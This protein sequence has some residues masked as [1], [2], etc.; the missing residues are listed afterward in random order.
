MAR[1]VVVGSVAVDE[2]ALVEGRVREGAHLEAVS[3]GSRLGGGAANTGTALVHAG[4]HVSLVS[5]VGEDATAD[6]ILA[7][8]REA[9]CDIAPIVRLPGPSTRSF[10]MIDEAGERTVVNLGRAAECGPPHRL[11]PVPADVVYV[12]SR[13]PDLAEVMREKARTCLVVAHAPP[14]VD[15]ARPCHVIVTS[16]SDID[17]G[18]AAAPFAAGRRIGGDTVRWVVVT[19]G[20]RGATAHSA[21]GSIA[22]PAPKV[23]P[24]D[25][26]GAGDSF[27]AGLIH[28]LAG[29]LAMAEALEIANAWGAESTLYEASALPPTAAVFQKP[30]A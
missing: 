9:G 20:A 11:L 7:R 5:A 1:I 6:W 24:V 13:S 8:L 27:A 23:R 14:L 29:G 25:T 30:E 2:V 4:H 10:I 19:D 12:R 28:G 15:G 3:R 21:E 17:D 26:T 18:F 22:R 16:R